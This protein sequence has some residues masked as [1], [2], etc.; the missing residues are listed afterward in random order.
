MQDNFSEDRD[1]KWPELKRTWLRKIDDSCLSIIIITENSLLNSNFKIQDFVTY[2]TDDSSLEMLKKIDKN[3]SCNLNTSLIISPS[4]NSFIK[5][6]L[7][8]RDKRS[9][10]DLYSQIKNDLSGLKILSPTSSINECGQLK[11]VFIIDE[12]LSFIN[13]TIKI[14]STTK[15]HLKEHEEFLNLIEMNR[16][17]L[18]IE[19]LIN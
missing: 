4:F 13:D 15:M 8:I 9:L 10:R 14:N 2:L 5:I 11:R 16:I 18:S 19:L 6:L 3:L 1:A 17:N 12:T 7:Y